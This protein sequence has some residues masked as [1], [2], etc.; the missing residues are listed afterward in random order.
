MKKTL[1]L[2]TIVT[3]LALTSHA[4][5]NA[6]ANGI[7]P[8]QVNQVNSTVDN[9]LPLIP[10][11]YAAKLASILCL[12]GFAGRAL[13]GYMRGGAWGAIT[14]TFFGHNTPNPAPANGGYPA[15]GA[16]GL[17]VKAPLL[18]LAVLGVVFMTGCSGTQTFEQASWSGFKGGATVPIPGTTLSFIN[19]TVA[20]GAGKSTTM[21]Q[22]IST[23]QLYSPSFAAY[24]HT[25][26]AQN[27]SGT[28]GGGTN[29]PM[30]GIVAGEADEASIT[31][32]YASVTSTN[33]ATLNGH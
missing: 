22:P 25:R 20:V 17:T 14:G 11:Q 8:D 15:K 9:L 5:T 27:I 30:A 16:Q 24:Q 18:M 29:A 31:T 7:T 6:L 10:S 28:T 32:G 1:A 23:N 21:H 19:V 4:Q 3:C 2:L 12:L 13:S 33:S 26:G